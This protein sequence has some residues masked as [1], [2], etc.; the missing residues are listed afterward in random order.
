MTNSSVLVFL[1]MF[2]QKCSVLDW[3]ATWIFTSVVVRTEVTEKCDVRLGQRSEYISGKRCAFLTRITTDVLGRRHGLVI[4]GMLNVR[5]PV[6]KFNTFFSDWIAAKRA[7]KTIIGRKARHAFASPHPQLDHACLIS[8]DSISSSQLSKWN[9][10]ILLSCSWP[11]FVGRHMRLFRIT[12]SVPVFEKKRD[13]Q[14][15]KG[16]RF[17]H[18]CFE[19]ASQPVSVEMCELFSSVYEHT[20][21]LSLMT[22]AVFQTY[23]CTFENANI[24]FSR[25]HITVIFASN[26]AVVKFL[27]IFFASKTQFIYCSRISKYFVCVY[28]CVPVELFRVARI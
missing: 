3:L 28:M 23:V 13:F 21:Q 19:Y 25:Y 24:Y 20:A 12:M 1:S 14:S 26:F 6:N 5:G 8:V 18:V 9:V 4:L 2:L 27:F 15:V 10:K 7:H 22:Y 16:C 17:F 11:H